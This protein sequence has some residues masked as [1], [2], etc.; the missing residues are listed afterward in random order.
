MEINNMKAF[1][2]LVDPD[3]AVS[4]SDVAKTATE[5]VVKAKCAVGRC[6]C[7][8]GLPS[9]IGFKADTLGEKEK[10]FFA[11]N[12]TGGK[13]AFLPPEVGKHLQRLEDKARNLVRNAA[14]CEDYIPVASYEPLCNAFAEVKAQYLAERDNVLAMWDALVA[15][16][17][18][19]VKALLAS[20]TGLTPSEEVAL[21]SALV[22]ALPT[23]EV[24][25][26]SFY[27]KLSIT[28]FPAIDPPEGLDQSLAA[29]VADGAKNELYSFALQAIETL[30][31]KAWAMLCSAAHG[32]IKEERVHT[33]TL[34]GLANASVELGVKNVFGNE[35]VSK[36]KT[37]LDVISREADE[38][39][40]E[41]AVEDAI[42]DVWEY[43]K[44][45]GI[46][47]SMKESPWTAKDLDTMLSNRSWFQ[48]N[49]MKVAG[50][51]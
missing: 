9:K 35:L 48:K 3:I 23:K 37:K 8:Y 10:T 16:Y 42:L 15:D 1:A 33:R 14:V 28:A 31:G 38:D 19:G 11:G 20:A 41:E 47:L 40:R 7:V 4:V 13:V 6:S 26:K 50:M 44:D 22:S 30:V 12:V 17:K 39:V 25:A 36:L 2:G 46:S 45:T 32:Y 49:Q 18:D 43:A 27:M 21:Y 29:A 34:T 51:A 5:N 24:Y